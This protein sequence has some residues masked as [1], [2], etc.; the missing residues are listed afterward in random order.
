LM[1][2]DFMARVLVSWNSMRWP[3]FMLCLAM[4]ELSRWYVLVVPL[5]PGQNGMPSLS[6]VDHT[7]FAVDAVNRVF[8]LSSS[9]TG[10]RKLATLCTVSLVPCWC[11][12]RLVQWKKEGHHCQIL[13]R[14]I[15]PVKWI[16]NV[17]DLPVTIATLYYGGIPIL[18]GDSCLH[19]ALAWC[20]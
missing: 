19:V 11:G 4:A 7:T 20:T 8:K 9:L 6:S 3:T 14:C 13:S 5:D 12:W 1:H 16:E 10:W 17:T 15:V 18:Q 2:P